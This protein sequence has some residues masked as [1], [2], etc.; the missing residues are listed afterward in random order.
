MHETRF[1][2][3]IIF[4]LKKALARHS[5]AARALVKVRLSPFCH[6][7][8]DGL[9]GTFEMVAEIEGFKNV[10]LE[11]SPLLLN[12]TCKDCGNVFEISK[13]TFH[14]NKCMSTN[15]DVKKE[16]EFIV[17]FIEIKTGTCK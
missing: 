5:P 13:I 12:I 7:T 6:V 3:E 9:K 17:D 11:I 8:A 15:I 1:V 4:H 10:E 16:K 2:E 14:C